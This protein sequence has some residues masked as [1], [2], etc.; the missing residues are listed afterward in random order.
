M[1]SPV[2]GQEAADRR[3]RPEAERSRCE[4]GGTLTKLQLIPDW[5]DKAGGRSRQ[6][7]DRTAA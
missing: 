5:S 1:A 7:E 2:D 4:I 6:R 3:S